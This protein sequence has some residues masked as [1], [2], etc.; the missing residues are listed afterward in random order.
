[1]LDAVILSDLHLGSANCQARLVCQL[2]ER[3]V[4]GDLP[5]RRL[6]L[7]G[8]V[9]DSIDFRRLGKAHW[10]VL[11]LIRKLSD[12]VE[13]VFWLAGNHDGSAEVVSHLLGVTVQEEYTLLTGGERLL[14]LHGHVFD[15]FI[16]SYPVLTWFADAV[17]GL[18]QKIDRTHRFAKMAKHGSKTF[19]RQRRKAGSR[20]VELARRGGCICWRGLRPHPRSCRGPRPAPPL[21]QQRLL[22]RAALHLSH[23]VGWGCRIADAPRRRAFVTGGLGRGGGDM[24]AKLAAS[25]KTMVQNVRPISSA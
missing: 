6:I 14:I 9:F 20:A 16:E 25:P 3:V 4:E 11:S 24:S 2:L 7:N 15:D 10:K 19:L 13:I 21:L 1:M 5:T 12:Q 22:D 18:L 17:Y 23:G 8:D